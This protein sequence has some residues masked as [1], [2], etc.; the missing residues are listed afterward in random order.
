ME[1]DEQLR[2]RIVKLAGNPPPL[3]IANLMLALRLPG[4]KTLK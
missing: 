1:R 3:I 2:S 4:G